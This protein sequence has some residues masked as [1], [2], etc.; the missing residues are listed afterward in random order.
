MKNKSKN[1]NFAL[2][3]SLVICISIIVV[4]AALWFIDSNG[5]SD[6]NI[7]AETTSTTAVSTATESGEI[8]TTSE[9]NVEISTPYCTLLCPESRYALIR[10]ESTET[11][12]LYTMNFYG[13]VNG[14]EY[15]ILNVY[16]SD[17]PVA[18]KIG[19]IQHNGEKL[20]FCVETF[21]MPDE[22]NQN[23]DDIVTYYSLVDIV[24]NIIGS[25]ELLP[26]YER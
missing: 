2:L 4:M 14:Q 10:Y 19:S 3:I 23:E 6:G 24:N 8:T 21:E 7:T 17:T 26:N 5:R 1:I 25:V 12:G 11:D 16:F 13:T 20:Y 9:R 15:S 22:E 18:S